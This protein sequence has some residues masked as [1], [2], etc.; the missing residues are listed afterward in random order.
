MLDPGLAATIAST[1]LYLREGNTVEELTLD[2]PDPATCNVR[3]K[4]I[5]CDLLN[6]WA[7]FVPFDH[8]IRALA[9]G[10][11]STPVKLWRLK[12]CILEGMLRAAQHRIA[13]KVE[14]EGWAGGISFHW[15]LKLSQIKK[16]WC[17]G[18][19]RFAILRWALNQDD[20]VWLRLR[21]T[22]HNQPCHH[23]Q[24]ATDIYPN[25]FWQFPIC[26]SCIRLQNLTP[27]SLYPNSPALVDLYRYEARTVDN[28][29]PESASIVW[30]QFQVDPGAGQREPPTDEEIRRLL[31]AHLQSTGPSNDCA[32]RACGV[33]DNTVG[34]WSRWCI[35]PTIV[36]R[37]L[38]RLPYLPDCLDQVAGDNDRSV[39]VCS[40]V[41]AQFRRL[42]RQEGAFLH[43]TTCQAKPVTWWI[44]ELLVFITSQAH[45]QL[46]LERFLPP[47]ARACT[48]DHQLLRITRTAPI[49][50]HTLHHASLLV[51][52]RKDV[53][54]GDPIGSVDLGSEFAA[55]LVATELIHPHLECN[56]EIK[57]YK[58]DCGNYHM[59]LIA[60]T[61]VGAGE[62]LTANTNTDNKTIVQFDG[63][64]H[65]DA[66]IG[67]AGA[68]LLQIGPR[69]LQLLR[70]GSLSL[71]PCKDNIVAESYGAELAMTLYSEYVRDCRR[72]Q[73][74]P[75]PLSI[76]QGDIKPLIHHLQFAGRFRRSDLVEVL[77][78]F[79]RLKS[80][81]APTA[82]PEYRPREANFLADYLAGEASGR[83]KGAISAPAEQATQAHRLEVDLPYELLLV[84]QAVILGQHQHGRIVLAL[85][86]IPCC[87]LPLVEQ[88][89][90][91]QGSRQLTLI[92]QLVT[93][94]C[95]LKKAL[96]V[97]YIAAAEDGLGRLYARQVSA[98]SLS[99]DARCLLYGQTHTE[100]DMSGAHYEILRRSTG[101]S[102]LPPIAQLREIIATDCNHTGEDFDTF[103]KLLPLRLL[104]SGADRALSYAREQGHYLSDRAIS[105]FR[106]IE[107]SEYTSPHSP[108]NPPPY[109]WRLVS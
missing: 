90:A 1:G 37:Y 61:N 88:F 83:L 8:L 104:N 68:A 20:D 47:T 96:C 94:T 107:T 74:A 72:E 26:E 27:A 77:D 79:H 84:N 33:G 81:L 97:E 65:R 75:L 2:H 101:A 46:R 103:V 18:I 21:G 16:S 43:Q 71:Y 108:S 67:G 45:L 41:L 36:A 32:C 15:L 60:L 95:M 13:Q 10:Q 73:T 7:P 87:A 25:G 58:C 64:A 24:Q 49:S 6:M 56:C 66:R 39:A 105:L 42:L 109:P 100:I 89:A 106:E 70:W 31:R 93:A 62:I 12:K 3:Q 59:R 44:D 11:G 63:S 85:R 57:I 9:Q 82:Q 80:G 54:Q 48:L 51:V 78:R 99:R 28:I 55:A 50:I 92:R 53:A 19:C 17:N 23:C 86:E 35:V 34:H 22:R 76:I 14:T 4:T 38:L 69:G 102:S 40:I 5:V 29:H 52:M 98:Q 30:S 91:G